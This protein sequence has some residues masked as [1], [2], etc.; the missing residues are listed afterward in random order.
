MWGHPEEAGGGVG[1]AG[2]AGPGAALVDSGLGAEGE[3]DEPG[4]AGGW[5]QPWGQEQD[6]DEDR[7]CLLLCVCGSQAMW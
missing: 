6:E 4:M 3:V 1:T 5:V 2:T 7:R